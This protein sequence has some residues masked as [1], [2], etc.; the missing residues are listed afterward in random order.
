M[1]G[2]KKHYPKPCVWCGKQFTPRKEGQRHCSLSCSAKN[3]SREQRARAMKRCA[4][5]ERMFYNRNSTAKYCG[6]DCYLAA[7][8]ARRMGNFFS[9]TPKQI[10]CPQCTK[11][12]MQRS[13][14]HQYCT[15]SCYKAFKRHQT[16]IRL[17]ATSR[18]ECKHCGT[19]LTMLGRVYCSKT[20]SN[21]HKYIA[22]LVFKKSCAICGTEFKT[23]NKGRL[24]CSRSCSNKATNRKKQDEAALRHDAYLKRQRLRETIERRVR[25]SKMMPLET[26]HAEAIKAYLKRGGTIKQFQPQDADQPNTAVPKN[27]WC[28]DQYDAEQ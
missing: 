13:Q 9:W 1:A 23:S 8:K 7:A 16:F 3:V 20:C 19:P 24:H 10:Q 4:Q 25:H 14:N 18:T 28:F 11:F 5:C 26:A 6:Q 21:K 2:E 22:R 27:F 15:R 17:K 12:F